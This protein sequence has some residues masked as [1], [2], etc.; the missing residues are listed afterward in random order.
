MFLGHF[1]V[2]LAA[3]PLAP[4]VSLGTLLLASQFIDLLWPTL[5]LLGIEQVR[6]EPGITA[7]T[8]LDFI[9]YPVS[10]SLL[11]VLGWSATFAVACFAIRRQRREALVL[12]LLVVSHWLL[13]AVVH[14]PDLPLFPGDSPRVG[15]GLW[16]SVPGTLAVELSLFAAGV[17]VY[18]RTTEARDSTGRWALYG[19]VA[20]LLLIYASNVLGPP[21]PGVEAIAWAGHAQW[22]LVAWGYWVDAHRRIRF[23]VAAC[24]NPGRAM[25]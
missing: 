10:H 3:K 7:M 9:H 24:Y 4:R 17:W 6:I 20:F 23:P 21:P 2:G 12:C 5:V 19:L 16:Q 22:L 11:A 8:P 13:D 1:A 14:R 25:R 18:L 15:L